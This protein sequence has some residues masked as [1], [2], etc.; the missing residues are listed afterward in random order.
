MKKLSTLLTVLIALICAWP[1]SAHDYRNTK[2]MVWGN[3]TGSWGANYDFV[4]NEELGAWLYDFQYTSTGNQAGEFGFRL[5]GS[6]TNWTSTGTT[7]SVGDTWTDIPTTGSGNNKISGLEL[8]G[9]YQ[10]QIA[11][12]EG[13][14]NLGRFKVIATA[15]SVTP[16]YIA[17]KIAALNINWSPDGSGCVEMAAGENKIYTIEFEGDGSEEVCFTTTLGA[18]GEDWDTFKKGRLVPYGVTGDG[19]EEVTIE[20]IGT[21]LDMKRADEGAWKLT[22]AGKYTVTVDLANNKVKFDCEMAAPNSYTFK[23]LDRT[24]WNWNEKGLKV[25]M[26]NSAAG[27]WVGSNLLECTEPAVDEIEG[28]KLYTYTLE[29]PEMASPYVRI[30]RGDQPSNCI[31]R[32]YTEGAVYTQIETDVETSLYYYGDRFGWANGFPLKYENGVYTLLTSFSNT[33]KFFR[34][35]T[36]MSDYGKQDVLKFGNIQSGNVQL[37][38]NDFNLAFDGLC[39]AGDNAYY[40]SSV[41][42]ETYTIRVKFNTET[43]GSIA[44][45]AFVEH[46]EARPIAKAVKQIEKDG[47]KAFGITLN[48]KWNDANKEDA[49]NERPV[50]DLIGEYLIC[51]DNKEVAEALNAA[52]KKEYELV[53]DQKL[54]LKDGVNQQV[55][56]WWITLPAATF[57]E[58]IWGADGATFTWEEID[59]TKD[60]GFDV[61]V[62]PGKGLCA[63]SSW[64]ALNYRRAE[65]VS[66]TLVIPELTVSLGTPEYGVEEMTLENPAHSGAAYTYDRVNT[67][68]VPFTVDNGVALGEGWTVDYTA[69]INNDAL[70]T[71]GEKGT[72]QNINPAGENFNVAVSAS[73]KRQGVEL[74]TAKSKSETTTLPSVEF[75]ALT[76]DTD[77]S[78]YLFAGDATH[79]D[80]AQGWAQIMDPKTTVYDM[81]IKQPFSGTELSRY[82]GY[83]GYKVVTNRGAHHDGHI[84]DQHKDNIYNGVPLVGT[85]GEIVGFDAL[86]G[87]AA[88]S[89]KT[90]EIALHI[91]HV[92]CAAEGGNADFNQPAAPE[93]VKVGVALEVVYPVYVNP[94]FVAADAPA[95]ARHRAAAREGGNIEVV[96]PAPISEDITVNDVEKT[97]AVDE[98]NFATT[99]V[100]NVSVADGDAEYFN[101]QGMRVENPE[102]GLYIR[103][104]GGTISKV[105]IR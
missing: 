67:V 49:L 88:K 10:I 83:I 65:K 102:S 86:E 64:Q 87:W 19:R 51:V 105:Y 104:Q 63:F 35:A 84:L 94:V 101:L 91:H 16:L 1:A 45:L 52:G 79:L 47:K 90:G 40:L 71:V 22:S 57:N 31:V 89:F 62:M 75:P 20:K 33:Q 56:G 76:V 9:Y 98:S 29:T 66:N 7:Y 103:R 53:E 68:A 18:N 21:E 95:A 2:P 46:P 77:P 70:I 92:A 36:K 97:A 26:F 44:A 81:A 60:Y 61:Y 73:Y 54:V 14:D 85:W 41:A 6:T 80:E 15:E 82:A 50:K 100:E 55:H 32:P 27:Q 12:Q 25:Y 59:P 93:N 28:G 30:V 34:I 72:L 69:M 11:P 24:G 99:G 38:V 17:G 13:N 42:D 58:L 37:D 3:L 74:A 23:F 4:W 78:F 96:N 43:T 5:E 39:N 48:V 8:N